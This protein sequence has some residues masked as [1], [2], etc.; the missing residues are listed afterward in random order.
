MAGESNKNK[1]R[2]IR[3]TN[4]AEDIPV[5]Q[6]TA[7]NLNA[8]VN[9]K[10]YDSV[11]PLW[12]NVLVDTS[13]KLLT[14]GGASPNSKRTQH[15]T[16]ADFDIG[17]FHLFASRFAKDIGTDSSYTDF[18]TFYINGAATFTN[19]VYSYVPC[20]NI[21]AP[22]AT[23]A[24][25]MIVPHIN[26]SPRLFTK[27]W[28][29]MYAYISALGGIANCRTYFGF[30]LGTDFNN[31]IVTAP[32]W[33]VDWK[34]TRLIA[35]NNKTLATGAVATGA[36]VKYR[37]ELDFSATPD[38]TEMRYYENDVLKKTMTNAQMDAI[39]STHN[40]TPFLAVRNTVSG[41][42]MRTYLAWIYAGGERR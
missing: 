12:R 39:L 36:W 14:A 5:K 8:T 16:D 6:A 22:S 11:T 42:I 40:F 23:N 35:Y 30:G 31:I 20:I 34:S 17:L 4:P 24:C 21:Y 28:I 19:A 1:W 10:G 7:S 38:I 25:G 27:I 2:G 3:P 41:T 18:C 29:E 13:G 32:T 26:F 33:C 9:L 15:A 37:I